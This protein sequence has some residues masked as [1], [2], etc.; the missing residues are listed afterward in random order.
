MADCI[1]NFDYAN[2]TRIL[3]GK[4]QIAMLPQV[5]PKGTTIFMTYG[6]GSI[7][8]NGVYDQVIKALEGY[9]IVEF[10]GIEANPDFDTLVKAVEIIRK[11]NMDNLFLLAVGGGSVSDGTKFIAAAS[12]YTKTVDPW[13]MVTSGGKG[14]TGAVPMGCVMTLPAVFL[15]Y[16]D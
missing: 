10:G 12:K 11:M 9:E 13:D 2:P 16:F 1:R 3:F 4:G 15:F 14:I 5:I 7:K 8:R 6:G